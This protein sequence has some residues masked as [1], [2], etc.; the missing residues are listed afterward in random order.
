VPILFTSIS[1]A[2]ILV[3]V[4]IFFSIRGRYLETRSYV[5]DSSSGHVHDLI[6]VGKVKPTCVHEALYVIVVIL[7]CI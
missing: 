4:T 2:Y 6:Y 3:L 5:G 7:A 1:M